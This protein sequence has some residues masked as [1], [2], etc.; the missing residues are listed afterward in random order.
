MTIVKA[1]TPNFV[2]ITPM[3]EGMGFD[4]TTCKFIKF[5]GEYQNYHVLDAL[6]AAVEA[7]TIDSST[8]VSQVFSSKKLFK[9]F[10]EELEVNSDTVRLHDRWCFALGAITNCED[11][12][13]WLSGL[14]AAATLLEHAEDTE[15]I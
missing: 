9:K 6:T 7:G 8:W 3:Y 4:S 10:L 15:Q 5:K 1:Y 2:E 11:D 14:E 12:S 13:Y